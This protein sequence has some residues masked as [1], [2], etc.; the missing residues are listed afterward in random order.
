LGKT[1]ELRL[2]EA[3]L[4]W[5]AFLDAHLEVEPRR[6]AGHRV[7]VGIASRAGLPRAGLPVADDVVEQ[8]AAAGFSGVVLQ[9]PRSPALADRIPGPHCVRIHPVDQPDLSL[10]AAV[11]A[12]DPDP[13]VIDKSETGGCLSMHEEAVLAGD[14]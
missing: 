2:G 13:V 8:E 5:R 11:D 3:G 12:F 10:D 9:S 7:G 6:L 4:F 14:L 1:L